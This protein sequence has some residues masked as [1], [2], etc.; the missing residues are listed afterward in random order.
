[1]LM[2]YSSSRRITAVRIKKRH[3]LF[4]KCQRPNPKI[5]G[6]V[7][8]F[9]LRTTYWHKKFLIC[10]GLMWGSRKTIHVHIALIIATSYSVSKVAGFFF[11]RKST[12]AGFFFLP[13]SSYMYLVKYHWDRLCKI[14]FFG[15]ITFFELRT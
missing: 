6:S 10:S 9:G 7:L 15:G 12:L 5:F 3:K 8:R 13:Y 14:V 1:M 4:G 11:P 2:V